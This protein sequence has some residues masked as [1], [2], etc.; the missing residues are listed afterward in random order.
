MHARKVGNFTCE[1]GPRS[2]DLCIG[3][4][5]MA[6]DRLNEDVTFGLGELEEQLGKSVEDCLGLGESVLG[7]G[8][9]GCG[10]LTFYS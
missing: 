3:S 7:L 10:I 8:E 9:S 4:N 6:C 2:P 5:G 1:S